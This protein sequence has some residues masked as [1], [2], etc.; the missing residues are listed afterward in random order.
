MSHKSVDFSIGEGVNTLK[1]EG[2][3]EVLALWEVTQKISSILWDDFAEIIEEKN[4]YLSTA[5]YLIYW[6][7]RT[8]NNP[9]MHSEVLDGLNQYF[10]GEYDWKIEKLTKDASL[11]E[12]AKEHIEGWVL[13]KRTVDLFIKRKS[14][15]WE[16]EFLTLKRE[17]FPKWQALIGWFLLDSDHENELG[18][19][20][21]VF[22]ALRIAW[23][24][25][26]WW[27]DIEYGEDTQ[28]KFYFVK[29]TKTSARVKL[30]LEDTIWEKYKDEI[31]RM[32]TPS[33]PRHMVDT[34]AFSMEIEGEEI[35]DE[36]SWKEL[37]T[38]LDTDL[39]KWWLAFGHHREII[40]K[41]SLD[42]S[43]INVSDAT[44][45]EFVRNMIQ[46]PIWTHD[47]IKKRF[48]ENDNNQETPFPE[49]LPI[50]RKM[51]SSLYT[52]EIQEICARDKF[53]LAQRH[54]IHNDLMHCNS[55]KWKECPYRSTLSAMISAIEFFDI[56]QRLSR[57]FYDSWDKEWFNLQ[58]PRN[59]QY[60]Y[61]F[62][63]KY[64]NHLDDLLAKFDQW[65]IIIPTYEHI[66]ATDLIKVRGIPLRFVWLSNEFLYVDEFWQSPIE[67]LLHDADHSLRMAEED[68]KYCEENNITREELKIKSVKFAKEYGETIKL[69]KTDSEEEKEIKKLKK[70]ILF[71]ICHEDSKSLLPD[72]IVKAIQEEEWKDIHR[73][74]VVPDENWEFYNR[75][76]TIVSQWWVSP[77][78]FVLHKLQHGFF[79]Q[80][81]NQ[82]TQIVSPKYRT[83]DYIA[84]AA[85]EMLIELGGD[86][87]PDAD[88][89]SNGYVSYEWLLKRTCSKTVGKTHHTDRRD[90]NIWEYWDGTEI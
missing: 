17:V 79:D 55:E 46:D 45:H 53:A 38:A 3:N 28:S 41:L 83:S 20:A 73:E 12:M 59:Q 22:S 25:V 11:A 87:S 75:E 89:D 33:D 2:T 51:M 78:A 82:I 77:L 67:F 26:L 4:V 29:N 84:R 8:K 90:K 80:V 63:T 66:W 88:L 9:R 5:L 35:L 81:D 34:V 40:S 10:G 23:Q 54:L 70:I 69:R 15:K 1:T 86:I 74:S 64:K 31:M 16:D 57:W 50:V 24:K 32:V 71:E 56:T 85:Y 37:G 21:N 58:D 42:T 13:V 30:F 61:F 43:K 18:V 49:L 27:G 7:H 47:M 48:E 39:D 19:S 52:P 44:H 72:V 68:E 76:K 60:A 65:E 14:D 62:R 36:L 6:F